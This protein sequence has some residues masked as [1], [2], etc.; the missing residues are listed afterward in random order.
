MTDLAALKAELLAGHPETGAYS[1]DNATAAGE[2]N[3]V[4]RTLPI[5]SLSGDAV[6]AATDGAEF[7]LLSD[8]KQAL[9][10]SLCGRSEIDPFGTSNIALLQHVFGG[11][12]T[13]QANL[14]S[15]R[16]RD[17]SRAVELRFSRVRE[18][19]VEQAR[20]L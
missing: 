11:G 20:A 18:G 12:S 8:H 10:M 3:L 16:N 14:Q 13:T 15:L 6:F 19:T 4:N 2:I 17:V 1:V 5:P 7:I 9:W